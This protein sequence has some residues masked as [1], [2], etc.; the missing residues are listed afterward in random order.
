MEGVGRWVDRLSVDNS[1]GER[2]AVS[3]HSVGERWAVSGHSGGGGG[4]RW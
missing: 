3:G 1:V 2:W 4:D